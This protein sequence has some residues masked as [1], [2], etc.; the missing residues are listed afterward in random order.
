MPS[1]HTDVCAATP[2]FVWYADR[3]EN[4]R[5]LHWLT[6]VARH[7]CWQ[8]INLCPRFFPHLFSSPP[9][10]PPRVRMR[11]SGATGAAPAD[12]TWPGLSW[13]GH[14]PLDSW[15]LAAGQQVWKRK[16][17]T[18]ARFRGCLAKHVWLHYD[19]TARPP[20][21]AMTYGDVFFLSFR[22]SAARGPAAPQSDGSQ[23]LVPTACLVFS[24]S[25]KQ[26]LVLRE[27]F[28]ACRDTSRD[29]SS[30][31]VALLG[32]LDRLPAAPSCPLVAPPTCD[33]SP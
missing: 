12:Q 3:R 28:F 21:P 11:A 24:S 19:A 1:Q 31:A 9:P 23:R 32:D 26:S 16:A 29:E 7:R 4:A 18:R 6:C 20:L 5:G 33:P 25:S 2:C 17:T 10:L 27:S 30:R 8:P 13:P 22:T 15:Q 14:R